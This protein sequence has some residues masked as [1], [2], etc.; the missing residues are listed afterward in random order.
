[1][2]SMMLTLKLI[3]LLAHP[4]FALFLA[5]ATPVVVSAAVD[6]S[7]AGV[8]PGAEQKAA[9]PLAPVSIPIPE[10]TKR[11]EEVAKLLRDFKALALPNPA[12]EKI[13][14]RLPEISA[15][16]SPKLQSTIET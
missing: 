10:I 13:K 9:A 15:Q 8:A 7:T 12:I 16:L 6:I 4:V 14:T 5:M 1:M 11:A 3:A 2:K